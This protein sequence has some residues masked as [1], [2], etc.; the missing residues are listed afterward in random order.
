MPERIVIVGGGLAAHRAAH[1]ARR[2]GFA[3][4]LVV[5]SDEAR[6]P[7]DRPP[8][9]KQLLAGALAPEQVTLPGPEIECDWR[10]GVAATGLDLAAGVLYAGE[11]AVP[12]DGLIL[13]TGRRARPWPAP[14]GLS[15]FHTLRRLED[16]LALAEVARPGT[17]VVIVGGG[18]IGCEV[19]ATLR[20]LGV[21]AVT[22]VEI[23]PYLM[24][25][26]GPE[27]GER[28]VRLHR[29][30]GVDVRLGASVEGF[31][32]VNG[33]VCAVRLADGE[34]LEA[35]VVLLALGAIPN[36]EWLAGSGLTL[37][38]GAVVVDEHCLAVGAQN[39]AAAGDMAAFPHPHAAGPVSIEHWATAREMGAL[40]AH[41]LMVAAGERTPFRAVPTFWSD[42]YDH[43]IKSAGLL[44]AADAFTVVED[45]PDGP[46]LV[47]E[48]RRGEELVGAIG[49]NRPRALIDYQRT[50]AEA[51]A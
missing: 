46:G 10:L 1:T 7:Y 38:R 19:A 44:T 16:S 21:E 40:A 14:L 8:L 33:A 18:F 41:N 45:D 13:A 24:P 17:S 25:V 3:G 34:R 9:S 35:D 4:E 42:Q 29:N 31:D 49:F 47:I 15:G 43:K 48:A 26:A 5:I 30:H 37:E 20:G 39:V 23:A 6:A 50:L 36:T 22:I 27:V 28:A 32:G 12:Y 2:E 11:E 51:L